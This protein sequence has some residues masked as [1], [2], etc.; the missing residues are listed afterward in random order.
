[1]GIEILFNKAL[2]YAIEN[3]SIGSITNG[4]MHL[5]QKPKEMITTLRPSILLNTVSK[6]L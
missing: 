1:M 6:I 5:I 3:E 2:N 4:K